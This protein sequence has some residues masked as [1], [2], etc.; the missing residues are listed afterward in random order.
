MSVPVLSTSNESIHHYFSP[1]AFLRTGSIVSA[2]AINHHPNNFHA[3]KNKNNNNNSSSRYVTLAVIHL[4][5][6]TLNYISS[7]DWHCAL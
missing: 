7:G 2:Y 1:V 3:T 5:I 4:I 6:L